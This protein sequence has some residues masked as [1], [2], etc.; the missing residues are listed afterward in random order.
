MWNECNC[1][2]VWAF[3][4]IAKKADLFQSCGHC[5]VFHIC[6]HVECSTLKASS[7]RIWKSSTG[8]PSPPLA[9]FVV[10]FLRPT[11]L[12]IPGCLALCEWSHHRGYL[13]HE[14]FFLYSSSVYSCHLFLLS[15]SSVR[16]IPFLSFI[17]P[18][19]AWNSPLV[20]L[21]FWR[22]L[23]SFP[24][25]CFLL[26]LCIDHWGKLSYLSLLFFATLHSNGYIFPFLL[27]LSLLFYSQIFV[28]TP[29]TAFLPFCTS[30]SWEWYDPCLL[31][32]VMNLRP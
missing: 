18:I 26:F 32:S 20:S 1:A 11:W 2:I 29:E 24:L 5:W 23:Q 6:W 25:Y 28:R 15:P 17:K 30:F 8:I 21:I 22:D 19:F 12:C 7:F 10:C 27:C 9:L 13:G 14:D 4:G 16:S 31:Y 3:F